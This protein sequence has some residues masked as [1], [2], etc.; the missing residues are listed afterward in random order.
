MGAL[1]SA[2]I[3]IADYLAIQEAEVTSDLNGLGAYQEFG[4]PP[5]GNERWLHYIH[6]GRAGQIAEAHSDDNLWYT[7]QTIGCN[8]M[9]LPSALREAVLLVHYE[10]W[11]DIV[12]KWRLTHPK[13]TAEDST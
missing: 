5:D 13:T 4:H 2:A 7:G 10:M 9:S 3:P 6:C 11:L 1:R 8:P 12:A